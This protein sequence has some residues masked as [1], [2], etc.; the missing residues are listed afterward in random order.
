MFK[1]FFYTQIG[2]FLADIISVIIDL[3]SKSIFAVHLT[4]TIGFLMAM[5]S[6]R[7]MIKDEYKS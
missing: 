5:W 7:N 3:N 2:M 1:K 4:L 6:F